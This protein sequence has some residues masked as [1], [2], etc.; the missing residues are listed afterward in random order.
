MPKLTHD[1]FDR[2]MGR[3]RPMSLENPNKPL[4]WIKCNEVVYVEINDYIYYIDDSTNEQVMKKWKKLEA[5]IETFLED[6][7]ALISEFNEELS[8]IDDA[9]LNS[10]AK[11][12]KDV[13]IENIQD[14]DYLIEEYYEI[15]KLQKD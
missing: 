2:H 11:T 9:E 14:D 4:V 6:Y 10:E 12:I 7:N 8:G 13:H 5:R 3:K 1:E 15:L